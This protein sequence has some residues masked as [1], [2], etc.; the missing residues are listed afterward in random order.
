[1]V[2]KVRVVEASKTLKA[3]LSNVSTLEEF[4]FNFIRN[5]IK[6]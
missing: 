6:R 3:T 1:V 4:H 5:L 2:G